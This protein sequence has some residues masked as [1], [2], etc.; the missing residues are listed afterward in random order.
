[1]RTWSIVDEPLWEPSPATSTATR[2][3]D[4]AGTGCSSGVQGRV[5]ARRARCHTAHTVTDAST[6]AVG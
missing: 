1:V 2:R 4:G 3:S 6:I 5:D